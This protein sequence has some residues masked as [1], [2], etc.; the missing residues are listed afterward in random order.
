MPR[1]IT[2]LDIGGSSIKVAIAERSNNGRPFLKAVFAEP[3]A[4]VR[5]GTIVDLPDALTALTRAFER[6]RKIAPQA[7][8]NVYVGVGTPQVKVQQSRGIVAVSRADNEIYEE[9][10]NRVVK[11]SQAVTVGAN[12]IVV[13]NISR[14]FIVDGVGDI[15]HPVGLSGSRL[16][17]V[18]VITDVFEPHVKVLVQLVE[19]AGARIGGLV[20]GPLAASRAALSK[21]QKGLGTALLDIGFGT[22]GLCLYEE[23]KLA[24]VANFPVGAGNV[25]KDIAVGL[26]IPIE[27]AEEV[28]L[29]YGYAIARELNPKEAIDLRKFSPDARGRV[30]RRFVAE[31]IESRLTEI[32]EFVGEALRLSGK[33]NE[34]AGGAVLVG[35]GAKIPGITDLVKQELKLSSHIGCAIRDEWGV[36]SGEH[37]ETLEDPSFVCALG[38]ALWGVD[39]EGWVPRETR[40]SRFRL[41]NVLKYFSP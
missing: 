14:E 22:T 36:E 10:V 4:G 37:E 26:K 13:H 11:A 5:K 24:D 38:I 2:G 18:S 35:G 25:T 32:L 28:K 33:A 12:R 39:E 30:S 27:A 8:K 34:L 29:R 17:V 9:D 20:V 21:T 7:L 16:E 1:F 23:D 6:I 31:I 15:A 19:T 40:G 41:R 3:S